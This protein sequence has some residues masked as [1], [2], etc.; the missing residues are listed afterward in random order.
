MI[1]KF[2]HKF[3]IGQRVYHIT[4]ESPVGIIIDIKYTMMHGVLYIVAYT[5]NDEAT[6]Y[7]HELSTERVIV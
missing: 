4:P 5:Y 1:Q 7:E 2:E 3:E 6:C